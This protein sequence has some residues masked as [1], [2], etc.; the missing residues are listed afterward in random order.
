MKRFLIHAGFIG[1][2]VILLL[3]FDEILHKSA[4]HGCKSKLEQIDKESRILELKAWRSQQPSASLFKKDS[5]GTLIP[6]F[7]L[8]AVPKSLPYRI[9]VTDSNGYVG[10]TDHKGNLVIPHQFKEVDFF[11]NGIAAFRGTK[12]NRDLRGLI[13]YMGNI[14]LIYKDVYL[15]EDFYGFNEDAQVAIYVRNFDLF[16]LD[17]NT[18]RY[19]YMDC[20]GRQIFKN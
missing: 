15:D 18:R 16:D 14:F 12:N 20:T 1:L 10:F 9:A 13:D 3:L 11:R 17:D 5:K 6:E 19:G 8:D 7:N 2:T 4:L